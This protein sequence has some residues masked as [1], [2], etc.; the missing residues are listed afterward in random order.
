MKAVP[1]PAVQHCAGTTVCA[2]SGSDPAFDAEVAELFARLGSVTQCEEADLP[3]FQ[4]MSGM[5]G[6]F[7]QHCGWLQ[8]FLQKEARLSGPEAQRYLCSFFRTLLCDASGGTPG[9]PGDGDY[10]VKTCGH[11]ASNP[12]DKFL[13]AG[14]VE[15]FE[16][17]CAAQTK[18]GINVQA[19]GIMES[20]RKHTDE[21][22]YAL[23]QRLTKK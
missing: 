11:V 9:S 17:L 2:K 18:G 22:L 20:N 3:V 6:P 8:E 16:E 10:S 5:M 15:T 19:M 12:T 23:L 4:V 7:Y 14:T 1:L 13:S 21:A